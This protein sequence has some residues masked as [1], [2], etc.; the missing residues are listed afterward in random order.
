MPSL[1]A[2]VP[3]ADERG[4]LAEADAFVEIIR[5][6]R[7]AWQGNEEEVVE[8]VKTRYDNYEAITVD[9]LDRVQP[10]DAL[11]IW[12]HGAAQVDRIYSRSNGADP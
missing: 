4:L 1:F 5:R 3:W 8:V 11:Y 6:N 7:K 12:G 9:K 10:N 2:Y